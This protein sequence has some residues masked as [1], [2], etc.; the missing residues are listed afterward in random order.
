MQLLQLLLAL[1]VKDAKVALAVKV[2]VVVKV[3]LVALVAKDAAV[4][5]VA[6]ATKTVLW[7]IRFNKRA[8]ADCLFFV[9]QAS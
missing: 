4:V 7:L 3:V 6:Q 2:A 1:A 5:L 9:K 8:V